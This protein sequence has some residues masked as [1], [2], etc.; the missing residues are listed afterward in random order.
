[1]SEPDFITEPSRNIPVYRR[2]D[3]LV[4]GG[5][6]VGCAAVSAA[7]MGADVVLVERYGHLGGMSTGGFVLWIDRMTDWEGRQVITGI[8]RSEERR[9]GKEFRSR[10][11]PYP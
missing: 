7:R 9:V 2:C 1:M 8:A 4:V 3:V 10:W 5:G 6:P 11:S